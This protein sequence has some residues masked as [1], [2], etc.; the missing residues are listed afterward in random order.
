[1]NV[2]I[3]GGDGFIGSYLRKLH[4]SKQDTVLIVDINNIRTKDAADIFIKEDLSVDTKNKIQS[5]IN[6]YKPD[7]VYNCVAIANP[8]FYTKYPIQT[9]NLDFLINH[10]IITQLIHNKIP[11]MH[12]STSEVYGKK[13]SK[14]YT[15]DTTDFIIGP[16]KKCR[17]IYATSKILLEQIIFG[18]SADCCIVRPQNFCG[19]DLDWLPS[20]EQ[21]T[22][23]KWIPR[24]PACIINNLFCNKPLNIVL[25]GSQKRC[26]TD[27]QEAVHGLYSITQSWEKCRGQV[28]NVGN[29]N[30]EIAVKDFILIL[31]HKWNSFV[32]REYYHT[33]GVNYMTGE[34]LYGEGYEDCERRLFSSEKITLATEWKP[35]VSIDQITTD[36]IKN[37]FTN[38]RKFFSK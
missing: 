34:S 23:K 2:L 35:S 32:P 20:I 38:Y 21:N 9:F 4:I 26:Y 3:L 36:L 19:W 28:F 15:E 12:F 31:K 27:I 11:F 8:D 25:P 17:W 16:S 6:K 13:W 5:L 1:M 7:F 14:M 30:N 33:G 10:D 29:P 37:S 22:D 18:H 24:L